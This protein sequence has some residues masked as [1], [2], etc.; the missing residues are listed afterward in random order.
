MQITSI[1]RAHKDHPCDGIRVSA[2]RN[3]HTHCVGSFSPNH[4]CK[5]KQA[6]NIAAILWNA[7]KK[8]GIL[9]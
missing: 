7:R 9:L 4:N 5:Y 1:F 8:M 3:L 6:V 2:A